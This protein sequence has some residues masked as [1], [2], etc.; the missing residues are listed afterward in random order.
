MHTGT[1]SKPTGG[2]GVLAG[3]EVSTAGRLRSVWMAAD[4]CPSVS[5]LS[6]C[7]LRVIAS[8]L[9]EQRTIAFA[10]ELHR[11]GESTTCLAPQSTSTPRVSRISACPPR[12]YRASGCV[13]TTVKCSPASHGLVAALIGTGGRGHRPAPLVSRITG[14]GTTGLLRLPLPTARTPGAGILRGR[15]MCRAGRPSIVR[16]RLPLRPLLKTGR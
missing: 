9:D 5:R 16:S 2:P 15:P 7:A 8:D 1:K 12:L 10:S 4:W 3:F 11:V 6:A 14:G 13:R